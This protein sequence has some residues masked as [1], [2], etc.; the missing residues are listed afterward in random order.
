[1]AD[2]ADLPDVTFTVNQ[3]V[4]PPARTQA[5]DAAGRF[6]SWE[7]V[8]GVSQGDAPA[9]GSSSPPAAPAAPAATTP[10]VDPLVR[11][12]AVSLG[13]TEAEAATMTPAEVS[14]LL[15]VSRAA[16]KP[17]EEAPPAPP[18]EEVIDWG[19]DEA[20]QP[21][22]EDSYVPQF[23]KAIKE[24]F[25]AKKALKALQAQVEALTSQQRAE[26]STTLLTRVNTI[27]EKHPNI[28]GK[29]EVDPNSP[30]G[31]RRI[32][33]YQHLN[34]LKTMTTPESDAEAAHNALFGDLTSTPAPA[35]SPVNGQTR[36]TPEQ[37]AA[38]QMMAPTAR[39]GQD[40]PMNDRQKRIREVEAKLREE[41]V[42]TQSSDADDNSDLPD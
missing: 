27:L 6:Q 17:A 8:E 5:R 7:G 29:G 4:T 9:A 38:A 36:I 16:S 31:R 14:R 25:E 42:L 15:R 22:T 19:K 21:L 24:S 33:V 18:A 3:I 41:G 23:A 11:E 20:G 10:T 37:W 28:Y 12:V 40:Q 35:K 39:R 30:Q 26:R 2:N 13:F 32:Q 1:M 34:T